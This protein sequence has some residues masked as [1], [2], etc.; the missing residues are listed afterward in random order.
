V[1][2]SLVLFSDETFFDKCHIL[3]SANSF[4]NI[5]YIKGRVRGRKKRMFAKPKDTVGEWWK[6]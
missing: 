1:V 6:V 2:W 3:P 5:M 4:T